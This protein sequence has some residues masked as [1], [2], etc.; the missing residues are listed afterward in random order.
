MKRIFLYFLPILALI[1]AACSGVSAS[2]APAP[3]SSNSNANESSTSPLQ[4][5]DKQGAVTVTVTPINLTNPGQTLEFD[6]SLETHSV[7]LNMNVASLS[8]LKT[9]TG[10]S[11]KGTAW[12]GP[13][14]GHHVEGKL[15]F[16]ANQDGK[17]ILQGAKT[18]TLTIENID[19]KVRTFSWDI[20]K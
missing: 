4:R 14:G 8:T 17:S 19:A 18:V 7:D 3:A 15:S 10:V 11:V 12:N 1:L 2:T 20:T 13:N 5:T 9:D 16:P 6:V